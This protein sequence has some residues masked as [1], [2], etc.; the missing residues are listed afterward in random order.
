MFSA[1]TLR[2]FQSRRWL[3]G[4]WRGSSPDGGYFFERRAFI[5]DSTIA[6]W[7]Y[8]QD[9]TFTHVRE[10][11][12]MMFRAGVIASVGA[13][14]RWEASHL[15]AAPVDF[16]PVHG[17]SNRFSFEGK[18]HDRWTANLAWRDRAGQPQRAVFTMQR[19]R[20]ERP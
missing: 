3:E 5:N 14:S 1:Y 19:T 4:D 8:A 9:S 11:A 10:T 13:A 7:T 12:E 17:A 16:G 18:L 2:N 20:R 15:D 6:S